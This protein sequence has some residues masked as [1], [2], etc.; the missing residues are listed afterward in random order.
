[1][2]INMKDKPRF[3][4]NK[5]FFEQK[6]HALDFYEEEKR[7]IT[8][9]VTIGG[10]FIHPWLYFHLNYFQTP[11]PHKDGQ[12]KIMC[13]PLDD[14][15]IY[16]IDT[17]HEA[18]EK[19]L[20]M[21]LFGSRGVS[22]STVLTSLSNW[23]ATIKPNG[24]TSIIGGSEG[25]LS[26]ISALLETTFTNMHPAFYLPRL[27][28]DWSS[29]IEFGVKEKNNTKHIHSR[30]SITNANKGGKSESEKGAGLSPVGFIIDEFGKFSPKGVLQS[31]IPSF[32][33]QYGAKLV[34][35]LAGTGG[36]QV[37][38]KDAKEILEN[39]SEYNLLM[40]NWDRLDRSCPEESITWEES[41]NT[42]FGTFTPAQMSY[43]L[44]V[45][46]I[47]ISLQEHLGIVH[48]DLGNI[49]INVTDWTAAS[50]YIEDEYEKLKTETS[51]NK[52]RMYYPT[53][54]AHCFLTESTNPF[55]V[56]VA[57][58]RIV[59]LEQT[60]KIGKDIEIIKDRSKSRAEFVSKKRAAVSH[61]GGPIDA[62]TILFGELP[63]VAPPD[64]MYVSGLDGYK[65]DV[66]ETDSLGAL[67]VI[68]RRNLEPNQP[69]E[70]IAA[71]YTSRPARMRDFFIT[72][73]RII[74]A[75]NAKML[76]EAVD[77][78]FKQFLE[79]KNEHFQWLYPALSFTSSSSTGK[80]TGV[81]KFGLYP[82]VGNNEYRFNLFVDMCWEE[83]VVGLDEEGNQII[84]YGIEFLDDIDL[85]KEVVSY[86]KGGN[87]DRIDGFSHALVQARELDKKGITPK[88]RKQKATLSEKEFARKQRLTGKNPYGMRSPSPQKGDKRKNQRIN[89]F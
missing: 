74:K 71:S 13:P 17:Y 18:E 85:L 28:T 11:I 76:I 22:K 55:P 36:N 37:L 65:L 7:K 12:E 31:A 72:G 8:D 2:F 63:E 38:S 43:R 70:T 57:N 6:K 50:Q 9:G 4:P 23:L 82:T 48:P 56:A 41:K 49:D 27:V 67:Y 83:H 26:A 35:T 88:S 24:T 75:F 52:Y 66:S 53:K 5:H 40:M 16:T 47:K 89:P 14:N 61:P 30:I 64:N 58:R 42:P 78:G 62:P 87:F 54:T 86:F 73:E 20:G 60:G 32:K 3:E 44:S 80:Y 59:E 84:K 68:K 21:C 10:Y 69:C 19:S 1:M 77:M 45:P 46:K 33:T 79:D 29:K 25:D 81:T 51:K 39:P 34:H 15:I